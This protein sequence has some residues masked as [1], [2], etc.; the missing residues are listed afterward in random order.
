M[1]FTHGGIVLIFLP[2]VAPICPE[3]A[4][5]ALRDR[6]SLGDHPTDVRIITGNSPTIVLTAS[7]CDDHRP[8][9]RTTIA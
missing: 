6:V 7:D 3:N 4:M 2:S 5:L 8:Q 1:T 9:S